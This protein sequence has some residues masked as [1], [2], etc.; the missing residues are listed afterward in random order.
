MKIQMITAEARE[1]CDAEG[2]AATRSIATPMELT[3]I[4]PALQFS[5]NIIGEQRLNDR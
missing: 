3:S 4:I 5:F 1:H 2:K